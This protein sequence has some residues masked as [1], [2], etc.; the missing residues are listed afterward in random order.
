MDLK[1]C[2]FWLYSYPVSVSPVYRQSGVISKRERFRHAPYSN[3]FAFFSFFYYS[4]ILF[5][6]IL[7]S[8]SVPHSSCFSMLPSFFVHHYHLVLLY[9]FLFLSVPHCFLLIP[10][11]S[12]ISMPLSLSLNLIRDEVDRIRGRRVFPNTFCGLSNHRLRVDLKAREWNPLKWPSSPPTSPRHPRSASK[13]RDATVGKGADADADLMQLF[14]V[15]VT[16]TEERHLRQNPHP[17]GASVV[18]LSDRIN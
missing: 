7:F 8:F 10:L 2:F 6:R 13:K 5:Y 4:L 18:D 12:P 16:I 9:Q 3:N 1:A 14:P 15:S 11:S 17:V